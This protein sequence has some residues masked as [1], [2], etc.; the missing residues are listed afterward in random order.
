MDHDVD[1]VSHL[2]EVRGTFSDPQHMQEAASELAMSGFDRA[3][4][5]L[6]ARGHTLDE[7]A[8]SGAAKP[9]DSE[10][11]ARQARTL[12]SSTVGAAV[13]LAAA[14]ITV[15]TG[16]AAA[17]AVAAAVLAGGAA[18]GLTAA[19]VGAGAN[20][21]QHEREA[22]AEHGTLTL[23]VR[24]KTDADVAAATKILRAHGADNV[25]TIE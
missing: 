1:E 15:A 4:M 14:G 20:T 6:P 16:G 17:P 24:T 12:S 8:S 11:D 22:Q 23:A 19:A 9:V 13:G 3:D 10:E 2:R 21:E 18:G 5:T 7:A 25:E